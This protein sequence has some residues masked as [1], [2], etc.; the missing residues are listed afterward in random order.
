MFL[1]WFNNFTQLMVSIERYIIC[2]IEV[3]P[4]VIMLSNWGFCTA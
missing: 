4:I 2:V 3:M 1:V